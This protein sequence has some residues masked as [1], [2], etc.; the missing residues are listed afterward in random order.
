MRWS[1]SISLWIRERKTERMGW[2][3]SAASSF[4]PL[5]TAVSSL[6]LSQFVHFHFQMLNQVELNRKNGVT[7]LCIQQLSPTHCDCRSTWRFSWEEGRMQICQQQSRRN[8][9]AWTFNWS[10]GVEV[11]TWGFLKSRH[12][13]TLSTLFVKPNNTKSQFYPSA[14]QPPV[15][16]YCGRKNPH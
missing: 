12:H 4:P 6:S 11:S 5:L 16:S 15:T 8:R 1:L 7:T 2:Q 3:P 10:S 14:S 13:S 9:N